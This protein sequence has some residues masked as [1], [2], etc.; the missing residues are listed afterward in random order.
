MGIL[1][2]HMGKFTQVLHVS[3]NYDCVNTQYG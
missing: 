3:C 1:T 2:Q